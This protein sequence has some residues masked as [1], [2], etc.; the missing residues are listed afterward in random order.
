MFS[1]AFTEKKDAMKKERERKGSFIKGMP[2]AHGYRYVVMTP[3]DNPRRP[4]NPV[5]WD[6]GLGLYSA[7][8]RA[9]GGTV[10]GT[11][12]TKKAAL[13]DLRDRLRR[14][15]KGE[16]AGASR[17]YFPGSNPRENAGMYLKYFPVNAAWAF[18]FGDDIRTARPTDMGGY[19]PFFPDKKDAIW[20]AKAQGLTVGRGGKVSSRQGNP[21]D[22]IVMGANPAHAREI[23]VEPGQTITLRVNPSGEI[24]GHMI[25]GLPCTREPGHKGPH[26]PQGATLRP[27]SRHNWGGSA[28]RNPSAESIR[29]GFIGAPARRVP[30]Y[31]ESGMPA[32]DYALLGK[33]LT[34]YV[35]PLAGGQI[36]KIEGRGVQ[37]VSDETARQIWFVAGDQDVT[38]HLEQFG[39]RPAGNGRYEL[40]EAVRIDYKQRKEHVPDPANDEWKHFFGEETDVRPRVFFDA[41]NKRLLLEGGE[42]RIEARGIV[43]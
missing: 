12:T 18:V 43:N 11:G 25:G 4:R 15:R 26:L 28:R 8:K 21:M 2:T 42:Y 22:L 24:C 23:T 13:H 7:W 41:I 1:G 29:E 16:T 27:A 33:L 36:L 34:L 40:G 35:R 37:V 3:R 5:V 10:Y 20:A 6:E 30:T 9:K 32:G 31:N 38:A 17:G 39:A 14:Y 19:G